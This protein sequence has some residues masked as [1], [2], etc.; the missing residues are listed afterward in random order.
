MDD[1]DHQ[2][3]LILKCQFTS[4]RYYLFVFGCEH[5]SNYT[6]FVRKT[7][8]EI[9]EHIGDMNKPLIDDETTIIAINFDSSRK[10]G[11]KFIPIK[12]TFKQYNEAKKSEIH[13]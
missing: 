10:F 2:L 1:E 6:I 5:F 8:N 4:D 13:H 9:K 11:E 12:M 7:Y 3:E